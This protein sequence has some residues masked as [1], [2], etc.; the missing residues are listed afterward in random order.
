[1]PTNEMGPVVFLE[2]ELAKGLSCEEDED[3]E[4][5]EGDNHDAADDTVA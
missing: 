5:E 2:P 3:E 4:K 1:M